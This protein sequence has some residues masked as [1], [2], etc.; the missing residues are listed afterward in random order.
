MNEIIKRNTIIENPLLPD[1]K[2]IHY[3]NA[4]SEAKNIIFF[5]NHE[6]SLPFQYEDSLS[7]QR[8]IYLLDHQLLKNY[9]EDLISDALG[10]LGTKEGRLLKEKIK[11]YLTTRL[12]S[13]IFSPSP[14]ESSNITLESFFVHPVPSSEL[15]HTVYN[16][17][18]DSFFT[19]IPLFYQMIDRIVVY[20]YQK[21]EDRKPPFKICKLPDKLPFKEYITTLHWKGII[22]LIKRRDFICRECHSDK[23]LETHHLTYDHLYREQYYLGD[24][25]LLCHSC[26][27]KVHDKVK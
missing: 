16:E 6:K 26:H 9:G 22:C 11:D 1:D 19:N 2:I 14:C 25:I 18:K 24:L 7:T 10:E 23:Y 15:F 21:E 8:S 13:G 17:Y 20:E 5:W 4:S 12:V 3:E 27:S